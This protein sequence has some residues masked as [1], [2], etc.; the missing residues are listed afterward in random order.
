M[1]FSIIVHYDQKD[2]RLVAEVIHTTDQIERIE[3]RGKNR[4][5]ILQNNRPLLESKNLKSRKPNWKLIE[6]KMNNI[7]LLEQIISTLEYVRK[8]S[9]QAPRSVKPYKL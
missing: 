3:V 5:I 1:K 6:G 7:Y 8:K 4:S 2:L 9:N